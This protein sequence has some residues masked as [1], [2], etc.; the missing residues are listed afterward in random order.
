MHD[1]ASNGHLE[2]L[3]FLLNR[4][5]NAIAKTDD[6][7][8]VLDFLVIWR[9]QHMLDTP[10]EQ[11]YQSIV[12]KLSEAL[13]KSGHQRTPVQK[14][15]EAETPQRIERKRSHISLD[16]DFEMDTRPKEYVEAM[17]T[18]R[19]RPKSLQKPSVSKQSALI[20]ENEVIEDETWLEDDVRKVTRKRKTASPY[21][22]QSK[23]SSIEIKDLRKS[24]DVGLKSP[25]KLSNLQKEFRN[26]GAQSSSNH[27]TEYVQV[28]ENLRNRPRMVSPKATT[29]KAL[30]SADE[31][32][33]EYNWLDDDVRNTNNK[34]KS[35]SPYKKSASIRNDNNNP[36]I[37]TN[38]EELNRLE[39]DNISHLSFKS[40]NSVIIS[41]N[42]D[43]ERYFRVISPVKKL[44][45]NKRQ[46]TLKRF[47]LTRDAVEADSTS[48]PS[49]TIVQSNRQLMKKTP[50]F[51]VGPIGI[52]PTIPIDVKIDGKLYRVPVLMS[53][54]NILTIKWLADE[55]AARY[56][57]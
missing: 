43:E 37:N 12:K 31:E 38:R 50:L 55:A 16:H 4:G 15:S 49:Q 8:S 28:M 39:D 18:L 46:V 48:S 24:K 36:A 3:Q 45:K 21:K 32:D 57:K 33:F 17:E 53:Q 10:K 1:A 42:S 9:S 2:I 52:D 22:L 25:Q 41:D 30:I 19:H 14:P 29:S 23:R 26:D 44:T 35:C 7:E 20:L 6:G 54:I 51:D 47:G 13:E 56:A 11:L 5:A 27:T 40:V 34:R